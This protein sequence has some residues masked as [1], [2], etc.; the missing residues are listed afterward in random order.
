[1]EKYYYYFHIFKKSSISFW[2]FRNKEIENVSNLKNSK[3]QL[4]PNFIW[5]NNIM[6]ICTNNIMLLNIFKNFKLKLDQLKF[7]L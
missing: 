2:C 6:L 4:E 5:V 3:V 1:M 7:D